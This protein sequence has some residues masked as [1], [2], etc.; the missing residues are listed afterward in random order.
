MIYFENGE[1]KQWNQNSSV[2]MLLK[3]CNKI[4]LKCLSR[5]GLDHILINDNTNVIK[6]LFELLHGKTPIFMAIV[7]LAL[8]PL[9]KKL[10]FGDNLCKQ[11]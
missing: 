7:S 3:N 6:Y 9:V 11:F 8:S 2:R 4:S 10:F 5:V 1:N